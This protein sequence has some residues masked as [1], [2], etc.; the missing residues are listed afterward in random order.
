MRYRAAVMPWTID[1]QNARTENIAVAHQRKYDEWN[2]AVAGG[3]HPKDAA[4]G[5]RCEPYENYSG[6]RYTIR[7]SK[8]H[9]VYFRVDD[10][11]Q[12]VTVDKIGSHK[13]PPGW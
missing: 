8:E 6:D 4:E 13:Q 3:T 12:T 2:Q 7:L 5:A 10:T 11:G 9:R 1:D